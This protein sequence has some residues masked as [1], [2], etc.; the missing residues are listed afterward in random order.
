MV[1]TL[2]SGAQ[3]KVGVKEFTI[4]RGR[5]E[6]ELRRLEWTYD[7]DLLG[8]SL[9]WLDMSQVAAVHTE[10][11]HGRGDATRDRDPVSAGSP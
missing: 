7:N 6:G 1:V 8:T 3:I 10:R 4:A 11:E 2:K 5:L 9:N